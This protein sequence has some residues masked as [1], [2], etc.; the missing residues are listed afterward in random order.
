MKR[1]YKLMNQW[2]NTSLSEYLTFF[3]I[4]RGGASENLICSSQIQ[5]NKLDLN[6]EADVLEKDQ[7]S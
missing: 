5:L 2:I 1:T 7:T 4:I 6:F 3:E